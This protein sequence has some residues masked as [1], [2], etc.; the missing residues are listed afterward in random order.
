LLYVANGSKPFVFRDFPRGVPYVNFD[1]GEPIV[2][3]G[4]YCLMTNHF[5]LLLKEISENGISKFM[6]KVLTSYSSYLN[7][8]YGK[9]GKLFEG[10]FKAKH[11]D[12]DEYLKYIFSYI[13]LNPVKII[14]P[15]WKENGIK[16][17]ANAKQYLNDYMHSSYLD[18]IGKVRTENVIISRVDF[19][20]YFAD[21]KE[22]ELFISEW[23]LFKD[24]TV[25]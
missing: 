16:N 21:F 5:H 7:K 2:A 1:R 6:S 9:T 18:Y 15:M 12:T 23:L 17:R 11:L 13:H 19:P 24:D 3:I 20:D 4:A 25:T 14:D 10:V 8:K 22:F